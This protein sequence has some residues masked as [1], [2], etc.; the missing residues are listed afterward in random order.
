MHVST[1]ECMI[2]FKGRNVMKVNIKNRP[3]KWGSSHLNCAIQSTIISGPLNF[4]LANAP[5]QR[6]RQTHDVA[7]QLID[8]LTNQGYNLYT[9]NYYTSLSLATT[10]HEH[11]T[12][13]VGTVKANRKGYPDSLKNIRQFQKGNCSNKR[14]VSDWVVA[15]IQWLENCYYFD[16]NAP[17]NRLCCCGKEGQARSAVHWENDRGSSSTGFIKHVNG[18]SWCIWSPGNG[19][20]ML[21]R[22]K[23]SW[24]VFF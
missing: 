23:K 2:R 12:H 10:L 18:M 13:F 1:D 4:K 19:Y 3:T 11:Q 16:N 6:E 21:R 24:R 15:H 8:P 14:Y 9:D 7:M 22:W 5:C 17:C 20:K